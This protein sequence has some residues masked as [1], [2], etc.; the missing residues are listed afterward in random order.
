MTIY[1]LH[2]T[3][4]NFREYEEEKKIG[5]SQFCIREIQLPLYV[6]IYSR[7]S[8][9]LLWHQVTGWTI[10]NCHYFNFGL[11]NVFFFFCKIQP[12]IGYSMLTLGRGNPGRKPAPLKLNNN[13]K[14]SHG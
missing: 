10:L 1:V 7:A 14:E 12:N 11:Q 13:G 8:H 5:V 9:I 3:W 2:P 4:H 6:I